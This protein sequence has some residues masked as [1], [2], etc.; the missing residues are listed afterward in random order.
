MQRTQISA[1]RG[2]L[3]DIEDLARRC[4]AQSTYFPHVLSGIRYHANVATGNGYS[5][6]RLRYQTSPEQISAMQR[7]MEAL[8]KSLGSTVVLRDVGTMPT[9]RSHWPIIMKWM[10]FFIRCYVLDA[11]EASRQ[12][13]HD[14]APEI[15]DHALF[16]IL[17][18]VDVFTTRMISVMSESL[19]DMTDCLCHLWIHILLEEYTM[20]THNRLGPQISRTLSAFIELTTNSPIT[21]TEQLR[22]RDILESMGQERLE[23]L[24]RAIFTRI[25][26]L[27][28]EDPS[29][30]TVTTLEMILIMANGSASLV[31]LLHKHRVISLIFLYLERLILT[32]SA[33]PEVAW[34]V[35]ESNPRRCV[36]VCISYFYS[37]VRPRVNGGYPAAMIE[38]LER[39]AFE[40]IAIICAELP[41]PGAP[42]V[43]VVKGFFET[44]EI[45]LIH[46]SVFSK[47]LR[48]CRKLSKRNLTRTSDSTLL[49][50]AFTKTRDYIYGVEDELRRFSLTGVP[51]PQESCS[52]SKCPKSHCKRLQT[53]S[54]CNSVLFCGHDCQKRAWKTVH[55]EQCKEWQVMRRTFKTLPLSDRDLHY[56]RARVVA[57]LLAMRDIV[58]QRK[59]DYLQE[60]PDQARNRLVIMVQYVPDNHSIK[61]EFERWIVAIESTMKVRPQSEK[62]YTVSAPDPAAYSSIID[63]IV[64]NGTSGEFVCW[65]LKYPVSSVQRF[66]FL[67]YLRCPPSNTY[68]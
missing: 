28:I 35:I 56:F 34:K 32:P 23:V 21:L 25:G 9:L 26:F 68:S 50:D 30:I 20:D 62:G 48:S 14:S 55:R 47:A 65:E 49:W 53:C 63:P 42:V 4:Q 51:H 19:Y 52:Y 11:S 37:F 44:V 40:V 57:K 10:C 12:A 36:Q 38:S 46:R 41:N 1:A 66:E 59:Y 61:K 3:P 54:G 22:E 7:C 15:I 17:K 64:L 5:S 24:C 39:R 6:Y 18:L 8:R 29:A 33:S 16:N 67:P 27:D 60:N 2:S 13:I 45:S 58:S 43:Q 31:D